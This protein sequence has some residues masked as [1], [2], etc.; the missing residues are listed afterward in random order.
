MNFEDDTLFDENEYA[1]NVDNLTNN[2]ENLEPRDLSLRVDAQRDIVSR[3]PVLPPRGALDRQMEGHQ[4]PSPLPRVPAPVPL[5]FEGQRAQA[6]SP[7]LRNAGGVPLIPPRDRHTRAPSPVPNQQSLK[8]SAASIPDE[9]GKSKNCRNNPRGS[10]GAALASLADA[11][12]KK[13]TASANEPLMS[14]VMMMNMQMQQQSQQQFQMMMMYMMNN[15]NNHNSNDHKNNN[16][17]NDDYNNYQNKK[18]NDSMNYNM[19][20]YDHYN[21]GYGNSGRNTNTFNSSSP[22]T[23]SNQAPS[24]SSQDNDYTEDYDIES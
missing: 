10:A 18:R 21:S 19:Q 2:D 12:A 8:R 22:S 14:Q 24:T 6:P 3:L 16:T 4:A 13:Q 23:T 7:V 15:N 5:R 1:E 20:R 17:Q 9:R 11:Y